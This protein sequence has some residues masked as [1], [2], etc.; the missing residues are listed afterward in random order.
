MQPIEFEYAVESEFACDADS[1]ISLFSDIDNLIRCTSGVERCDRIGDS[2][3]AWTFVEKRELGLVF[4]PR[5]TLDYAWDGEGRL[6]WSTIR[7]DAESNVR[8]SACVD[9][10]AIAPARCLVRIRERIGFELP[11]SFITAKIVR[12]IARREAESDTK[13]L[14]HRMQESLVHNRQGD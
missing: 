8:V 2:T 13:D 5:F 9:F 3:Y 12:A 6:L 1:A 10:S 14:L 11:V 7:H 4:Q